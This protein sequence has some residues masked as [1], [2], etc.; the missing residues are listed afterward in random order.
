MEKQ[1]LSVVKW[2]KMIG[3]TFFVLGTLLKSL[4]FYKI[5]REIPVAS[6][7]ILVIGCMILSMSFFLKVYVMKN[8]YSRLLNMSFSIFLIGTLFIFMHLPGGNVMLTLTTIL[9][10]ILILFIYLSSR[11]NQE[12]ENLMN[13]LLTIIVILFVLVFF[14]ISWLMHYNSIFPT[15]N[16][17]NHVI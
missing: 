4:Y 10:P 9:I 2:T 12:N 17:N 16:G 13:D 7:P 3:L 14:L 15:I 5:V 11:N 6:N 8:L 1:I